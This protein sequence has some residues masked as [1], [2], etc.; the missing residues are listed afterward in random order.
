MS[1]NIYNINSWAQ[2]TNYNKN[3]IVIQN[4]L[5]YYAAFNHT[6]TTDFNTDLNGGSWLGNIYDRGQNKPFFQWK[7]S[8]RGSNEN[9]PKVKP[10][11]FGD[12]Y[13][14]RI[15]D[16]IN[17]LL[18]NYNFVFDVRDLSEATA[19]LHFLASRNASESFCFVPPAPRGNL[20]RFICPK[21]SDIQEFLNNYQIQC[22]FIQNPV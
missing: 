3:D 6:S 10:I 15:P 11:Q 4:N 14:Q 7:P 20:L 2:S 1:Q 8:Y 12:G 18:L 5:Y 9:Q 21:W 16:G 22:N 19:I 13:T 17:N